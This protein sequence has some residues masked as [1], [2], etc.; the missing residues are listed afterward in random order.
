MITGIIMIALSC[1]TVAVCVLVMKYYGRYGGGDARRMIV[2]YENDGDLKK[3]TDA[4]EGAGCRVESIDFSCDRE[5]AKGLCK[6]YAVFGIDT[7]AR[8][9]S[10]AVSAVGH[11]P[12]VR[13]A[14]GDKQ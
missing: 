14:S 11:L 13:S 10:D 4:I 8:R 6:P 3:I 12:C 5:A 7:D 2:E 9:F 1:L